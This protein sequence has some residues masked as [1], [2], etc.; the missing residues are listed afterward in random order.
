MTSKLGDAINNYDKACEAFATVDAHWSNVGRERANCL[1]EINGAQ[2]TITT[3][4]VELQKNAPRGS[5]WA[6]ERIK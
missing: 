2:H 6:R 1:N 5:D 3:I 4:I